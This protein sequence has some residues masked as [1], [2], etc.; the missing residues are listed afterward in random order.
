MSQAIHVQKLLARAHAVLARVGPPSDHDELE[1]RIIRSPAGKRYVVKW[2]LPLIPPHRCYVEPF[3]G[4]A[5]LFFAKE[6]APEEVLNDRDAEIAFVYRFVQRMTPDTL[7]ELKRMYWKNSR[8]YFEKLK[9]KEPANDLERFHKFIY[10]NRFS[11]FS[12]PGRFASYNPGED[13]QVFRA[14]DKFIKGK[15]RLE[16]TI[17]RTGDYE[18]VIR[19]FDG[20]QT[21]FF[22]DPPFPGY[23]Q[24]VGEPDFDEE[25]FVRV[26]HE[27]RGRFLVTYGLK[28]DRALFDRFQVRRVMVPTAT[29]TGLERRPLLFIANYEIRKRKRARWARREDASAPTPARS[30]KGKHMPAARPAEPDAPMIE[31]ALRIPFQSWGGSAHYAKRLAQRF[32]KHKRYVEPF[33]GSAALFFHKERASEEVLADLD[34]EVA[35]AHKYIRDL[36]PARFEE[37]KKL[38]WKVTRTGFERARTI[39]P[40]SDAE[41]FWR[42]A[43]GRLCTWGAK[44]NMRGFSTMHEG[45]TYP[46]DDLW[47]FHERLQGVK[48]LAQD[49]RK[50]IQQFDGPDTLFFIDPPYEKEWSVAEG[51]PAT[52]I[53]GV[54]KGIQGQWVVAYTSS[55]AA[56][57]AFGDIGHVFTMTFHEARHS[58]AFAQNPRL[59][60]SKKPLPA[61]AKRHAD[62]QETPDPPS[63]AESGRPAPTQDQEMAPFYKR[64]VD[65]TQPIVK[66]AE[67][68]RY[69]LGVVLEPDVVDAQNERYSKEE[70]RRACHRFAEF[71]LNAGLMH[72]ELANGRIVILENYLAPC[73]FVAEN[74]EA[75]KEGTWLQG[76][77]YRDHE[78]WQKIKNGEL[79]GLSIGGSAIRKPTESTENTIEKDTKLEM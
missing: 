63:P 39:E 70:V 13:G 66:R 78:I 61:A 4:S 9:D 34:S 71:Y 21:F 41:R 52:E 36:T 58:G 33:C 73:D 67:E 32:P 35:F 44:P 60:A 1:K 26:L 14:F 59:F 40:S 5:A 46:L 64:V 68:E 6:P 22:L 74:G 62:S 15:E 55:T 69:T 72:R 45:Q 49:W 53:A 48:I 51:I 16:K 12:K 56:R 24:N 18:K 76:R 75:V 30:S 57:K 37:L 28:S 31:K 2:L 38:S 17:I 54:L 79:T 23:N 3:A 77:G 19:E 50:T 47:K 29:P 25:R 43:Y 42:L 11:Y 7:D 65:L 27:I 20:P 10:L 8:P